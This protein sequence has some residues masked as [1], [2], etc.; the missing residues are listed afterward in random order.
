MRDEGAGFQSNTNKITIIDREGNTTKFDLKE[1]IEVAK[2][3]VGYV[4]KIINKKWS[5]F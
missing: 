4:Q 2:D 3:I 5:S 1:K